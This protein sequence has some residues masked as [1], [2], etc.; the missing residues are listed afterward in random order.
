MK[1][2]GVVVKPPL[3]RKRTL[4][5]TPPKTIP[6]LRIMPMNHP[7]AFIYR[8]LEL[9][10][11]TGASAEL[12]DREF[13]LKQVSIEFQRF[14][15]LVPDDLKKN[16]LL[17]GFHNLLIFWFTKEIFEFFYPSSVGLFNRDPYYN[18][19]LKS[20]FNCVV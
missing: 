20:P 1:Q 9:F 13:F 8:S 18:G 10:R 17:L 19:L 7:M 6:P 2:K 4:E 3:K 16:A 11:I 12:D 15:Q 5:P 14:C